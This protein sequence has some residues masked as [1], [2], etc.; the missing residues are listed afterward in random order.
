MDGD[1]GLVW[2]VAEA[3][4]SLRNL[5]LPVPV[6]PSIRTVVVVGAMSDQ[7]KDLRSEGTYRGCSE[8][9]LLADLGAK[10]ASSSWRFA[11]ARGSTSRQ[12]CRGSDGLV[13]SHS[14]YA[15]ANGFINTVACGLIVTG[16]WRLHFLISFMP[17]SLGILRSVM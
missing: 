9:M 2:C 14:T 17:S 7:L 3:H 13:R 10:A 6:S 12:R 15:H 8:R 4:E 16:S 5:P 1:E 11:P